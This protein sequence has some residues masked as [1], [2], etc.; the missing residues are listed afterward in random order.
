MKLLVLGSTGLLGQAIVR[1]GRARGYEIVGMARSGADWSVDVTNARQLME[2]MAAIQP[3]AVINCAAIVNLAACEHDP[4]MAY[5][6]NAR[7]ASILAQLSQQ[8]GFKL[9][10]VSTDHYYIGDGPLA[11][12][13]RAPVSLFN[14]YAR[15]KYV[16]EV[17]TGLA[18]DALILRTNIVG[19]RWREGAPTFAE[20]VIGALMR[21]EPLSLFDDVFTSSLHVDAFAA[22]MFDLLGKNAEGIYNLASREVSSKR[23]FILALAEQMGINPDWATIGSGKSLTPAR[24]DSMGLAVDKAETLLGYRLP[25]LRETVARIAQE[26]RSGHPG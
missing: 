16:G 21:R 6:I 26:W 2:A 7:P 4:G 5:Q 13:E 9:V 19:H 8:M 23:T 15:T 24:A 3:E 11:H 10:Y 1:I 22:A 18:P 20:W 25:G 17:F 14:E 12:D